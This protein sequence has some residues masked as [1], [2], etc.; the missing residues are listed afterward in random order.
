[1]TTICGEGVR[2]WDKWCAKRVQAKPCGDKGFQEGVRIWDSR[3]GIAR[4][5]RAHPDHSGRRVLE[6][7]G[8]SLHTCLGG[9]TRRGCW[10]GESGD[11]VGALDSPMSD[12]GSVWPLVCCSAEGASTLLPYVRVMGW[13]LV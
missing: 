6:A 4:I 5:P 9:S 1:M 3:A 11:G 7:G 8:G 12:S 10:S 13:E 2:I